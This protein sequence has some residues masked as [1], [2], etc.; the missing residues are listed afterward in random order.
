MDS[1]EEPP[2]AEASGS[3]LPPPPKSTS[4]LIMDA[5]TDVPQTSEM[6]HQSVV[7]LADGAYAVPGLNTVQS[8][9]STRGDKMGKRVKAGKRT[10]WVRFAEGET[11][12]SVKQAAG[13]KAGKRSAKPTKKSLKADEAKKKTKAEKPVDFRALKV[14]SEEILAKPISAF[15][16]FGF[17]QR[18]V[19]KKQAKST[20]VKE[21]VKAV[22]E[23]WLLLSDADRAKYEQMS[24]EEVKYCE[25][26]AIA[27][28]AAAKREA[29]AE[30]AAAARAA[31]A[32]RASAAAMAAASARQ[33]AA[34]RE[35]AAAREA[36]LADSAAAEADDAAAAA[37]DAAAAAALPADAADAADAAASEPPM[38]EP[39]PMV[40]G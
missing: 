27:R 37:D 39:I 20:T 11:P 30:K 18:G 40:V 15:V 32:D 28:E 1:A 5:L 9:L 35:A 22:G 38:G 10:H 7:N 17:S 23:R 13:K 26:A 25:N 21:V 3:A 14:R 34:E 4:A 12:T 31:A 24:N 6:V 33:E 8:A 29:A 36:M 2:A 19:L 16:L